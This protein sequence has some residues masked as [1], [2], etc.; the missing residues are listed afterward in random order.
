MR[1]FVGRKIYIGDYIAYP[2]R[3]GPFLWMNKAKVLD[4]SHG[5]LKVKKRGDKRVITLKNIGNVI[6]LVK[7]P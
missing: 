6:V 2:S 1:D 4:V 7:E 3:S 5:M